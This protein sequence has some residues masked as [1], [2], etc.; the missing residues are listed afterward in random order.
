MSVRG[1]GP[2]LIGGEG[3]AMLCRVA[4]IGD[5]LITFNMTTEGAP[6][7]VRK[8]H[9]RT[10]EEGRDPSALRLVVAV[11]DGTTSDDL[12]RY[13]DAGF[14]EFYYVAGTEVPAE[15]NAARE[16]IRRFADRVVNVA[17]KL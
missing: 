2:V 4:R 11:F 12:S 10:R 9:D 14:T 16:A 3:G 6:I 8:V 17:S 15:A 5:G 1:T 7:A 13:R